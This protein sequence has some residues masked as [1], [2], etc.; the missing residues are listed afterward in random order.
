M[1]D[2]QRLSL[3]IQLAFDLK[4]AKQFSSLTR[5]FTEK[6]CD[7]SS[8]GRDVGKHTRCSSIHMWVLSIRAGNN[9]AA[10]RGE[11]ERLFVV[12]SHRKP[13]G[14][15]CMWQGCV[16][17]GATCTILSLS[18]LGKQWESFAV[19]SYPGWIWRSAP[20]RNREICALFHSDL[21]L[22]VMQWSRWCWTACPSFVPTKAMGN[23]GSCHKFTSC[24]NMV[25]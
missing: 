9:P 15:P 2:V 21:E 19:C 25:V 6:C 7:H 22:G 17:S 3:Q 14:F 4:K 5:C 18:P 10:C 20:H 13:G 11:R 24:C 1:K 23:L 8:L 12:P 16:T